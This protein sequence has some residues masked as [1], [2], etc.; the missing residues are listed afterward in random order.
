MQTQRKRRCC[1]IGR[2]FCGVFSTRYVP[3]SV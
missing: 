2:N 3:C 1:L